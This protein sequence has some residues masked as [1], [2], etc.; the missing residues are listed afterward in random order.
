MHPT[1]DV[2]RGCCTN[3]AH[4]RLFYPVVHRCEDAP[5]H[6]EPSDEKCTDMGGWYTF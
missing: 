2:T 4:L 3:G 5:A 6:W 1:T